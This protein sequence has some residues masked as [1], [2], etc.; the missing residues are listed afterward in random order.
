MLLVFKN[1]F[2]LITLCKGVA[3]VCSWEYCLLKVALVTLK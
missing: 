2:L 1:H 3:I